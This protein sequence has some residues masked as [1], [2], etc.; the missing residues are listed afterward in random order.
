MFKKLFSAAAVM[1]LAWLIASVVI[2]LIM[3]SS[4]YIITSLSNFGF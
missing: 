3:L 4:F 1:A 2:G